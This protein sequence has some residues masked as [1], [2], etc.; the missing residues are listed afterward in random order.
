MADV[1]AK[2]MF[3]PKDGRTGPAIS[4]YRPNH[5]IRDDYLTSGEHH[6]YGQKII[7]LGETVLGTITFITPE[8]YPECLWIGKVIR[9]QEGS[10]IIGS[11]EITKIFNDMLLKRG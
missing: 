8:A 1:E 6:Y 3:F 10:R 4:G 9:I 2:I 5:L 7:E 11:A